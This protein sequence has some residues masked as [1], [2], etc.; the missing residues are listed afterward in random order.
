MSLMSAIKRALLPH[1]AKP[2]R[3]IS[4][5]FRGLAMEMDP[6]CSMQFWAG[7]YECET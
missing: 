5:A 1:G 3:V 2:H 6:Q 4:G 7:L